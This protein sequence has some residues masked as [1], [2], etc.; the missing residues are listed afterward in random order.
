[1]VQPSQKL[2]VIFPLGNGCLF[3]TNGSLE[4]LVDGDGKLFG[5]MYWLQ[6]VIH[7]VYF[8]CRSFYTLCSLKKICLS[9]PHIPIEKSVKKWSNFPIIS[10]GYRSTNMF[11]SKRVVLI[12]SHRMFLMLT[13]KNALMKVL[14]CVILGG[15]LSRWY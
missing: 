12:H 10:N 8:D 1:M 2:S 11:A 14:I 15:R 6:S 4:S 7:R 13:R 3:W 5:H 9:F